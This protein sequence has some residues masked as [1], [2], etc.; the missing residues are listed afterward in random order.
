MCLCD[1]HA[2]LSSPRFSGQV[3]EVIARAMSAGVTRLVT[4]GTDLPSSEAE[5]TI[6]QSSP[7]VYA[8]VGVH[9]HDA[10][11]ALRTDSRAGAEP[12]LDESVFARLAA[13]AGRPGV[14]AIGEIGLDY[15]YDLS[16]RQVQRA[17]LARQLALAAALDLPVI[18][19]NRESDEDLMRIVDAAPGN[20]RGV[21]HCFLAGPE[22]A[23]WAVARGLY[24]GVAGPI[25][26]RNARGVPDVIRGVPLGRL[27]VE[28]DSPYLA[29]HPL[30]GQ[31]NEP[32]NVVRVAEGLAQVL[33]IGVQQVAENTTANACRLFGL[34]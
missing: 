16:P 13:L 22:M 1:S 8:A 21:L 24:I 28:T 19:H 4:C 26:F 5:W 23:S 20:L 9:G 18:L 34:D 2:H 14:V 29:P 32:A 27:L 25:T 10:V 33:G 31:R 12:A 17:V 6:A 30:R 15:H 7:G 3:P 11:S